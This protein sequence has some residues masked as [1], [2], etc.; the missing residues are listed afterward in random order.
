MVRTSGQRSATLYNFNTLSYVFFHQAI[1]TWSISLCCSE[2]D[3]APFTERLTHI[4]LKH[5]CC[6]FSLENS[7]VSV[8]Q[9]WIGAMALCLSTRVDLLTG[10]FT[11]QPGALVELFKGRAPDFWTLGL[12]ELVEGHCSGDFLLQGQPGHGVVSSLSLPSKRDQAVLGG[13]IKMGNI[14]M[15]GSSIRLSSISP[16]KEAGI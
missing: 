5:P 10:C 15:A 8:A 4:R 2:L 6:I 11:K 7:S 1:P 13:R 16:S 12:A 3:H 9:F 14:A